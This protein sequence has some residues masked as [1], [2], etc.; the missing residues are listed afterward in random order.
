MKRRLIRAGICLA[1][2]LTAGAVLFTQ[3]NL[4]LKVLSIMPGDVIVIDPG[5]GG[6]DGGA[7]SS[8]GV[9]E[10]TINLAIAQ[11]VKKMAQ[12]AGW[13][14]VLTREDDD[15][16]YEEDS[17]TIR[18]KKTQDLK[19]RRQMIE[20]IRPEAVVSIHLNSYREDTAVKGAQSFYPASGGER[21]VLAQSKKLAEILQNKVGSVANG[22]DNRSALAKSDV[23]LFKEVSC[24]ISIIECGFLSNPEDAA[25]LQE[26]QYQKEIAQAIYEAVMEFTGKEARKPIELI[27]SFEKQ[28]G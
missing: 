19:A 20:E 16:L 11:E 22:S 17:G 1:L 18:S 7:E 27:D 23:F 9:V 3:T 28:G 24:P 6:V 15:G 5:H 14:V 21:E 25:I 26:S 4:T 12:Q 10:K 13:Q 8:R 2:L